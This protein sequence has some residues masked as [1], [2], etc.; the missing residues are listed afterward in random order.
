MQTDSFTPLKQPVKDMMIPKRLAILLI[1]LACIPWT[2]GEAEPDPDPA[3]IPQ[4]A[5]VAGPD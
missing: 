5:A 4:P 3:A 2:F 1:S